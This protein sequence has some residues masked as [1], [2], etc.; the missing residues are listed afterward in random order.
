MS[1]DE[2][3]V[4]REEE[5]NPRDRFTLTITCAT[6]GNSRFDVQ[7]SEPVPLV[8][9]AAHTSALASHFLREAADD[10]TLSF[11]PTPPAEEE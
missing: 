9:L 4:P 2:T 3:P 1:K 10:Y 6:K 11:A 7:V 5:V 8:E